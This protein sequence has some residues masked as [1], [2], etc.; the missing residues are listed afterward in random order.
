MMQ[1]VEGKVAV[2]TG[3]A[4]GI[5]YGIARTFLKAGMKVVIADANPAHLNEVRAELKGANNVH[6][7][8]VDVTD[9]AAMEAA[10][11]EVERVFGK[12]HV[13]CN[14]AGVPSGEAMDEAS[15]EEWDWV[16]GVNL[17]GVVNGV[18]T[19]APRIKKHGEGG[20]IVN[21][22][23]M[24]GLIPLP[25]T[26]GIYSAS[27]FAVRGL[28]DSLRLALAK[29]GVG[30]SCLCPG[31]TRT[32]ILNVSRPGKAPREDAIFNDMSE[33][34]DPLEL[35]EAVL[36]GIKANAPYILPHG[37]FKEEVRE[38]FEEILAQFPE[39]QEVSEGRIA[40][41][42]RRREMTE[43]AKRGEAI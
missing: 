33:A 8:Q 15:Y 7:I 40:F 21:T 35:G 14:N 32:R 41:E 43:A 36:A 5:G 25:A 20:H 26:G 28:T 37:E 42:Q 16:L 27:K 4:S 38:L 34:M 18:K 30:V 22:A 9:R 11:D 19:F 12:V 29:D 23:S 10:A 3:G 13:V 24:A 17:G 1:D 6:F 31:L 2:V 39:G